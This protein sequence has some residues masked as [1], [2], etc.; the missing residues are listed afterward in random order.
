MPLQANEQGLLKR[1][2]QTLDDRP[3]KPDDDDYS[4]LYNPIYKEKGSGDPVFRLS[5]HIQW[6]P[7]ESVQYFSGFRGSGKTTELYRLKADLESAGFIVL[8]ADITEYL[9]VSEPIDIAEVLV[10]MSA[11]VGE[12]LGGEIAKNLIQESYWD[13]LRNYLTQTN[14]ALESVSARVPVPGLAGLGQGLEFKAALKT[15]PSFRRELQEVLKNR[16]GELKAHSNKFFED[17]VKAARTARP[18]HQGVVL[19]VDSMERIEGSRLSNQA[20]VVHSVERLFTSFAELLRVPSVHVVYT[21]PPWLK[22]VRQNS[23]DLVLIPNLPQWDRKSEQ[24]TPLAKGREVLRD[25]VHR[26]I[27][28]EPGACA[29]I[30]GTEGIQCEGF[31]E[32]LDQSGGHFRDLLRLVREVILSAE[33]LPISAAEIRH[34]ITA[35]RRQFLPISVEDAR[36]LEQIGRTRCVD[37]SDSSPET[38]MR[39]SRLLDSHL[40]L[41]FTNG[42]EWYDIH[43]MIQ[44]EVAA[45]LQRVPPDPVQQ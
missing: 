10:V 1:V 3:L 14:L 12:K 45:I 8:L 37:P 25:I 2:F 13:R 40:V 36:T 16:L 43:P 29:R 6:Q 39:L 42:E 41:Y 35:V 17:C 20:D 4:K 38:V 19:L 27:E 44:E 30:F 32:L 18:R 31:T 15:T 22:F 34:A 26:R 11:A 24:R 21:V 23:A 9:N 33:R 5:R 28:V 7:V